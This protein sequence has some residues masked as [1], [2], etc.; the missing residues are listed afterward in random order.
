MELVSSTADL[1]ELIELSL[2]PFESESIG[3]KLE[4]DLLNALRGI[5]I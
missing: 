5:N 4:S 1:I 2:G 3:K